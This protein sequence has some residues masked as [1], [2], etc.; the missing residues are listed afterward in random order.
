MAIAHLAYQCESFNLPFNPEDPDDPAVVDDTEVKKD[1]KE[2]EAAFATGDAAK[3]KEYLSPTGV[4]FYS[5]LL[6]AS[7]SEDLIEYGEAFKNRTLDI[8]NEGYAEY[9]F[10]VDG[11]EYT[12]SLVQVE[13]DKWMLTRF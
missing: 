2:I 1:A 6:E 13:D 10:K 4:E 7:S 11:K 5:D 12:V 9:T 3:V 8:L